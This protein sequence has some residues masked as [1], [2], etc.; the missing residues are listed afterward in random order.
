M[1]ADVESVSFDF[2]HPRESRLGLRAHSVKSC[3]ELLLALLFLRQLSEKK[4]QLLI[5]LDSDFLRLDSLARAHECIGDVLGVVVYPTDGC[6]L[7][8]RIR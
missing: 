5:L 7:I 6:E 8:V 2:A 3:L 4:L 1:I